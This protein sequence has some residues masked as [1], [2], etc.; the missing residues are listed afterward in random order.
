M[1]ENIPV[2][3]EFFFCRIIVDNHNTLGE[4]GDVSQ[5]LS[6]ATEPID[7]STTFYKS[8]EVDKD[9]L[10]YDFGKQNFPD[11]QP[12]EGYGYLKVAVA[13]KRREICKAKRVIVTEYDEVYNYD[14][15]NT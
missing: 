14:Y 4:G 9:V 13:N 8:I 12:Q 6:H 5:S 7:L 11:Y 1:T 3:S 10:M 2:V 15:A